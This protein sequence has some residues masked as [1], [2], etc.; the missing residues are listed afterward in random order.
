MKSSP[1]CGPKLS[2][3][4]VAPVN[5]PGKRAVA[6]LYSTYPWDPRPRRAAEALAR[7]EVSVEVI[8][9]KETDEELE[10]ESFGG[11]DITRIPLRHRRAGKFTYLAKYGSFILI[12]G[13]ILASRALRRPY[14]LVHVHNMPDVLVFSAIVP[15]ILG[16]KVILDLHDPM[17]ELMETIFG[18]RENGFLVGLLKKFE[19]WSIGFADV[20]ITCNDAFKRIFLSRSCSPE[21]I[22]VIMNSPDERIFWHREPWRLDPGVRDR[23][24]SFVIMYHGALEERHGLDLAVKAMRKVRERI[25]NAELRIYGRS[26]SF[27]EQVMDLV[28]KS[29]L[30]EAVRYLG[31]KSLE[32]ISDAISECDVGIIP[33]RR[34]KFT[35][36]NM[37]TRIFEFLSQARPVI[38]PRSA[39][40]MDY[41]G[42]EELVLFELGDADDLAAKIEFVFGHPQEMIG[43]VER[44]QEVYRKHKW[45][46]ERLRFLSLVD[47][48]LISSRR[49]LS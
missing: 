44:G 45:S 32:Q 1:D 2:D 10:R 4:N 35:Q 22:A 30:S 9:L 43:I 38:A 25:P 26:T 13:G 27:L 7:E 47:R 24:K 33:N 18:S 40:I 41:F 17:P 39:G 36:L 19:K 6:L 46:S 23:S 42:P 20:V 14:D 15:K 48:L 21:K 8:C 12:C 3:S 16:A 34:S 28:R 29:G 31:L 5:L 11:V 37:P 49:I